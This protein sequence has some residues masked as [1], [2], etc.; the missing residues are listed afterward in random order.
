MK[1]IVPIFA[2]AAQL[3]GTVS[4]Q[5]DSTVAANL[6]HFWSYGRSESVYPTRK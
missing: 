4:A 1:L 3:A 5:N 6:E 2:A